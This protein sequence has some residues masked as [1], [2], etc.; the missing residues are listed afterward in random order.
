MAQ[1]LNLQ[2]SSKPIPILYQDERVIVFDK[3]AG[4][5]VIPTPARETR[6]LVSIVNAQYAPAD[7]SYGLQLCHRLDR[8]TSGAIMFAKGK[9]N[10]KFMMELF[11]KRLIEK[12]YTAFIHGRLKIFKGELKGRISDFD[13][14]KFSKN[15]FAKFAQTRYKVIELNTEFSIVEVYPLTGRTNQIRIQFSQLGFP[16]VGERKYAFPR[17]YRLKFRRVALH[18]SRLH[19]KYPDTGRIVDVVAPMSQDM[20]NFLELH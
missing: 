12:T 1:V 18:A 13:Q 20:K 7:R 16:L 2:Q 17:D 9:K 5:L 19:W 11:E 10:Q 6:T 15:P 4:L 14:K 8:E 3:P